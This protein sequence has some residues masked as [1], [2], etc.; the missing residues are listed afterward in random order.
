[1]I[2][3][4]MISNNYV[5][6]QNLNFGE[7]LRIKKNNLFLIA[8]TTLPFFISTGIANANAEDSAAYEEAYAKCVARAEGDEI[9]FKACMDNSGFPPEESEAKEKLGK[10]RK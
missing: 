9:E 5:L 2:V 10:K 3:K 1:L 7:T 8:I 4:Y 6:G